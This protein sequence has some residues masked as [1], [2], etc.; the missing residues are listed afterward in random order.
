MCER[1]RAKV[2]ALLFIRRKGLVSHSP[3]DSAPDKSLYTVIKYCGPVPL[4]STLSHKI[5]ITFQIFYYEKYYYT[6]FCLDKEKITIF[7]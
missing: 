1:E 4:I 5:I 7:K 3:W 2:G 6:P